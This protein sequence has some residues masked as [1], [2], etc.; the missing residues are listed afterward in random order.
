VPVYMEESG[1]LAYQTSPPPAISKSSI[2]LNPSKDSCLKFEG[3]GATR[4]NPAYTPQYDR[5]LLDTI[6]ITI[7]IS[8]TILKC[9]VSDMISLLI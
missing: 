1:G 4:H 2:T 6:I 3:K 9:P 7:T 8:G 5:T